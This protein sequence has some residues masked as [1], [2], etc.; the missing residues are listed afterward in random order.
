MRFSVLRYNYR[1]T[2]IEEQNGK[3]IRTW[4]KLYS[5]LKDIIVDFPQFTMNE[6]RYMSRHSSIIRQKEK[7]KG[8][9]L[10]KIQPILINAPE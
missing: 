6:I 1:L 10:G 3:Q 2:K 5:Q 7:F 9:I 4:D 8:F